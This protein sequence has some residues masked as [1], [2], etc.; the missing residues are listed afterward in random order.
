M[1]ADD[2]PQ[3]RRIEPG[4]ARRAIDTLGGVYELL[5]L[6]AITRFR[7]RG[8]YWRWRFETAFGRGLPA[9]RGELI[10][11]VLSYGRW[12]HRMRRR[13]RRAA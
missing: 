11:R 9:S 7:F 8:R 3:R 1:R 12:M 6:A 13:A 10:R 4:A 2:A 5:R